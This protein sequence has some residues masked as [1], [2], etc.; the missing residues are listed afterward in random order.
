MPFRRS[1][2]P[3]VAVSGLLGLS[4]DARAAE[5]THVIAPNVNDAGIDPSR[6]SHQV[7]VAGDPAR[8][9]GKL[10]VIMAGGGANNLPPEWSELGTEGARLG[11]H[12]IVLAYKNEVPIAAA[13]PAGCGN[14]VEPPPSPVNCAID[15]RREILDG[16]GE[17]TV[18]AVDRPNSIEN[19]LTK[20]L[21]HLATTYPTEGWSP[22]LDTSGAEPAPKWSEIAMSGQSL[23]AGQAVVAGMMHPL[24]RVVA[25]GGWTDA[26]HG[27]VAPGSTPS[28]RYFTLIHARDN[29]FARTC[30]GYVGLG[31][32]QTCPL[33][34]FTVPP[35]TVDPANPLLAE[36]RQ[37]PFGA[38]QVVLNLEPF[39]LDG[40]TDPYHTST[41]RDGWIARDPDGMP[42][43][44]LLNAWRAVLGDS[45]ADTRL[46]QADNCPSVANA[47]QIDSDK[48]GIGD[49]CGPTV[50]AGT[51]GGSVPA[52]LALTMGPA[53]TFGAFT[54]GV[55]RTYDAST[56][57]TVISTAGD[58]ALSVSDPST[59]ATG[60]LV[61]GAFSLS[62]ALQAKA[63]SGA[64]AP[65]GTLQTYGG[66]VSNDV[67][68]IAF[69]QHI[70]TTQALRTGTYSKTLTFTLSTT[71]P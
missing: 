45:D 53:A 65:L 18:V 55:D 17:S 3:L 30:Y 32:A 70:G 37:A 39:R 35:A 63:G 7:F 22:F 15:A 2:V 23:G 27:W 58:A 49:A 64:F 71:T 28:S 43:R 19:R 69:R 46:D 25:F 1:L 51:A 20:A 47:E 11:Y 50:A 10:L 68:A 38:P 6:G 4:A 12:A 59:N 14:S 5:P 67:V 41:T 48:N 36:N 31:L 61:N 24:H 57:A 60:R 44:K 34:G 26:K 9:V 33:P 62:E 42:A 52:T 16:R 8:R 40:V 54:P 66:P 13:P 56:T 29:F 21:Q